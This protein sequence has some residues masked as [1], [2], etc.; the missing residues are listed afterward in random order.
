MKLRISS[1]DCALARSLAQT[2]NDVP[3]SFFGRLGSESFCP[4]CKNGSG[5]DAVRIIPPTG[6]VQFPRQASL[7][8]VHREPNYS[9]PNR[10]PLPLGVFQASLL[11][12][13]FRL[14]RLRQRRELTPDVLEEEPLLDCFGCHYALPLL[15]L[16]RSRQPI[17][18][19]RV[20]I[21]WKYLRCVQFKVD[22]AYRLVD[23]EPANYDFKN[24]TV[25]LR[26]QRKCVLRRGGRTFRISS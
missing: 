25:G 16:N 23:L 1:A 15:A 26:R 11:R 14:E 9:Q 6:S 8:S 4:D 10:P 5:I 2:P 12:L 13:L 3:S 17:F 18:D 22:L 19:P 7:S 24:F 21:E 20:I